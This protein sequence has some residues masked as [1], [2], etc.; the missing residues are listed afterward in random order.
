MLSNALN[1]AQSSLT[2]L[3]KSLDASQA[4]IN[5][6]N[7]PNVD[8]AEVLVEMQKLRITYR[9]NLAV[10]RTASQMLDEAIQMTDHRGH[11][12]DLFG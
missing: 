8:F 11:R 1:V 2:A 5:K 6:M 12:I 7:D 9:A 10:V 3:G 4:V